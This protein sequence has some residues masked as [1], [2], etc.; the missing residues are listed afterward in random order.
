MGCLR[1]TVWELT[2]DL[3]VNSMGY[4]YDPQ[5]QI[6]ARARRWRFMADSRVPCAEP[7]AMSSLPPAASS[8]TLEPCHREDSLQLRPATAAD[9]TFARDLARR[10]LLGYYGQYSLLWQDAGFDAGWAG[11]EN[12]LLCRGA[13]RLGFISLSRDSR[14]LFIR[15]I[16]VAPAFQRQGLGRQMITHVFA[17]ALAQGLQKVRLTVFKSNPAQALYTRLGFEVVGQDAYFYW[18]ERDYNMYEA[19]R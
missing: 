2:R 15:E 1:L 8:H 10:G 12:W 11:R 9:Q 5:R 19:S 17:M 3:S 6:L 4:F 18:M 16:H 14:A 7:R 13:Q